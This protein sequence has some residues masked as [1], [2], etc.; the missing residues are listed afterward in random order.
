MHNRI[1]DQ[2][3]KKK[4]QLKIKID[5]MLFLIKNGK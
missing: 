5:N 3:P 4:L 2:T 1:Y